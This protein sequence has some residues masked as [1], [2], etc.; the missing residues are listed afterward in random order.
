MEQ[1]VCIFN[2]LLSGLQESLRQFVNANSD[3]TLSNAENR[4]LSHGNRNDFF[5]SIFIFGI[6]FIVIMIFLFRN[7]QNNKHFNNF[8][9]GI[10]RNPDDEDLIN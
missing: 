3:S 9:E 10:E 5:G 4:I 7:Q 6:I 1:C 2:N 8:H